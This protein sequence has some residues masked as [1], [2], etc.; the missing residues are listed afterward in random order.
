MQHVGHV[1][2]VRPG[3]REEYLRRHATVWPELEAMMRA[4]GITTYVIYLWDEVVFSHM[5]VED[6]ERLV[7][8]Y[9]SDPVATRWEAAFADLLEYPGAD[10]QSGW[11]ERLEEVWSL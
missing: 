11:P 10:P 1:W 4:A 7:R 2:R 9:G 5:A 3:Q 6:Y 8:E